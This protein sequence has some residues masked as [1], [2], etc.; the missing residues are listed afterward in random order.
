MHYNLNRLRPLSIGLDDFFN[1]ADAFTN[2]VS[3][4]YPPY[5]INKYSDYEYTVELALAGYQKQDIEITSHDGVLT[6]SSAKQLDNIDESSVKSI[7]RGIS[8]RAF[9]RSFTLAD[10]VL[11]K[12]AR[13]RDGMLTI[14]LEQI[15]PEKKKVNTITIE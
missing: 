5:N 9:S 10:N 4:K 7:H 14:D 2:E 8:T 11:V 15:V 3:V 12:K 13:L 6:I 1:F